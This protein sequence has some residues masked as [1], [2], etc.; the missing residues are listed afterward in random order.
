MSTTQNVQ[1][2]QYKT[3]FKISMSKIVIY[4]EFCY[5][6]HEYCLQMKW[7]K[8]KMSMMG[9]ELVTELIGKNL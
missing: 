2:F 7:P 8:K 9:F 4:M 3:A 5:S 6:N 1:I